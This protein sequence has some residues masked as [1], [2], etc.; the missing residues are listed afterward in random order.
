MYVHADMPKIDATDSG[1]R[2][3]DELMYNTSGTTLAGSTFDNFDRGRGKKVHA[4]AVKVF[5]ERKLRATFSF[6][7]LV[8]EE[9][10]FS[11]IL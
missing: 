10:H 9:A 2:M 3:L 1:R 8:D 7:A 5:L 6:P 4:V 11:C